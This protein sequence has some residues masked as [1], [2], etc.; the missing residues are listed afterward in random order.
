MNGRGHGFGPQDQLPVEEV[1][2]RIQRVREDVTAAPSQ[3]LPNY[4]S[5]ML[6]ASAPPWLVE[7]TLSLMSDIRPQAN[8]TMLRAMANA[9][10]RGVLPDIDVPTV[11]LHGE[12]DAR[13]PLEVGR[14]LNA[15]MPASELVVLPGVGHLSN[16]E[17]ADAFN[18]EVRNFLRRVGQR[19]GAHGS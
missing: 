12:L 18:R 13:S 4:L 7:Q 2:R 3:W 6:T 9:D 1:E 8:L 14:E 16:L 15:R 11:V 17:A 19:R 5:G 10:L